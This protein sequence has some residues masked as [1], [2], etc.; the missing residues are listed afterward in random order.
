M[1]NSSLICGRE[2]FSLTDCRPW[3]GVTLRHHNREILPKST[4]SVDTSSLP[5]KEEA[6][7][8]CSKDAKIG[9][10]KITVTSVSHD[11]LKYEHPSV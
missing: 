8:L 1:L 5:W 3:C 10:E 6:R 7:Q 11:Q 4:S 2:L 9:A